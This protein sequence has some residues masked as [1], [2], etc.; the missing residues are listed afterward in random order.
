MLSSLGRL[1][2]HAA[3][4]LALAAAAVLLETA[5]GAQPG[6]TTPKFYSDDPLTADDDTAFDAS[7]ARE[8]ELSEAFDFL[9]NT[10][11]SPGEPARPRGKNGESGTGE[12]GRA[13]NVTTLDEVPDSSWFTNRIGVRDM[14]I[15]E[16]VR[17]PNKFEKLDATDWVIV[18]G[19]GPSGFHPGF[20]AS[21]PGDPNQV[22]QLEVD[23][24]DFPQLATGA[25]VIGTLIYHA[26][27]YNV[28][29]VYPIRVDPARITISEKATIRDASGQ[30]RFTR[31]DLDGVLRL[32]ARDSEGRVY[33]SASRFV[34]GKDLGRFKYHGTRPDDPND[35]H[36]HEHRRELR[37][38][39]VFGAWLAHDD[40]RAINTLDMLVSKDGRNYIRHYMFDFGAVL[41]SATRFPDTITSNHEYYVEKTS[42]LKALG[43]LGFWIPRYLRADYPDMP[44]SAGFVSN[45]AF[46]PPRWKANYA[47]A[48]FAN[49]QPDDAFWGARLVSRFSDEAIRAIVGQVGY[50]DPKATEHLTRTLIERRDTI[51]RVWLNGVN[52][53]VD[54][55]LAANGTLTFTNAAVAAG[56]AT[57]AAGYTLQWSRFDNETGVHQPIGEEVKA[58]EPSAPAPSALPSNAEYVSVAI[59]SNHP[60]HPAWNQPVQVYFRRSGGGWKTVGVYR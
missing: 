59:R 3:L 45:V 16:I 48:A 53:I 37:A 41:G 24:P 27:G 55:A 28:V 36:P 21:H 46:D 33:F 5:V 54:I 18:R 26:L 38:N 51:A 10:F 56:A 30:R 7:G 60:E 12:A 6:R 25:E 20:R 17:G 1:H 4:V 52:P 57:P 31:A 8:Y 32:A 19:K 14:P 13:A 15:S 42:N 40:S 34:E 2:S 35:I 11:G 58:T 9:E 43:S 39:R 44:S 50:D 29:D 49:M 23:P 47:N 22:Y